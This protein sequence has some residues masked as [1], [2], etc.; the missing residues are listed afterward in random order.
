MLIYILYK[1]LFSKIY[2]WKIN[3]PFLNLIT[4]IDTKSIIWIFTLYKYFV[5]WS[6]LPTPSF[7]HLLFTTTSCIHT[8]VTTRSHFIYLFI[9]FPLIHYK[10]LKCKHQHNKQ[11]TPSALYLPWFISIAVCCAMFTTPSKKHIIV[12]QWVIN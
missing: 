11:V 3:K 6:Y 9:D 4:S 2:T 12:A 8:T 7:V 1:I 10:K 5:V